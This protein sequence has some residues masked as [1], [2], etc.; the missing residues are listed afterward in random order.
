[1]LMAK[2]QHYHDYLYLTIKQIKLFM[3][4]NNITDVD[5]KKSVYVCC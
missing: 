2:E 1:M 5:P 4:L 3:Y